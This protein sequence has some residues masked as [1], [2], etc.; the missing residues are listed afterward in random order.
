VCA[1]EAHDAWSGVPHCAMAEVASDAP[2]DIEKAAAAVARWCA[3]WRRRR[4]GGAG[5]GAE[6]EEEAVPSF[7]PAE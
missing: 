2:E 3:L 4:G 1:E 7:P 6:G 5:A